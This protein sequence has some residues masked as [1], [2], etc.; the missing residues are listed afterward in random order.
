[1][2]QLV[3]MGC[4]VQARSGQPVERRS[5]QGADDDAGVGIGE[6]DEMRS[7]GWH[8]SVSSYSL[9]G[10]AGSFSVAPP[11]IIRARITSVHCLVMT[12]VSRG[13]GAAL[14]CRVL[15]TAVSRS[16]A[17]ARQDDATV[18]THQRVDQHP[19][20]EDW[21]EHLLQVGRREGTEGL[22]FLE[23]VNGWAKC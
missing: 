10:I 4:G 9:A 23:A 21:V 8:V 2:L 15:V 7:H 18:F 11:L 22:A 6:V 20:E 5:E 17:F 14:V 3:R 12:R 19:F 1:M 16:I 13:R